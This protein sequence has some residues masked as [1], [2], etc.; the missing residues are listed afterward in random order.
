MLGISIACRAQGLG[1][2]GYDG[3]GMSWSAMLQAPRGVEH[4]ISY[5][6]AS[7]SFFAAL[8]R[9]ASASALAT[10]RSVS[11]AAGTSESGGHVQGCIHHRVSAS[12]SSLRVCVGRSIVVATCSYILVRVAGV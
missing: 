8:R 11:L 3:K 6:L 2:E 10:L 4:T 12:S 7:F 5:L 9:D 1:L